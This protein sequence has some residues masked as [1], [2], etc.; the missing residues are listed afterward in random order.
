MAYTLTQDALNFIKET[1][2]ESIKLL[3]TLCQIPAPSGKEELRAEFV[4]KWFEDNG[5]KEVYIDDALN[6]VCPV[7]CEDGKDIIVFMAHTDVVFPDMT[8]LPLVKDGNIY[9]CPGIGDDTACLV[10]MMLVAK[11]VIKKGLTSDY[12]ILFV[13][14]SCEE[15]LGN[16][17]GGREIMKNYGGRVKELYTFDGSYDHI[18][19]RCVGSHRYEITFETEGGHSYSAF[20]KTNAIAEMSKFITDLYKCEVP[21]KEDCK[22]T[23]NVGIVEG[24]TSVNT[25]AQNAKMLYEYRSDDRE[26]LA[27]MQEFFEK[28]VKEYKQN[29]KAE[30]KV[31]LLGDRPC[32]G[33]VDQ[34]RLDKMIKNSIAICE[35]YSGMPCIEES[36]S[37]DCNIPM[38]M[39]VPAVCF[40]THISKGAHTREEWLD[41]T[42]M[43][44]GYKITAE[45]ILSYFN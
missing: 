15:G 1:E 22:T 41:I 28:T 29:G 37:T 4:K 43:P 21:V 12:G 17:K 36:A 20:G 27:I 14:N 44:I 16:L 8:T 33:E 18:Y 39:G 2:Q 24:G 34:A 38:S 7:G 25:I 45:I 9:R 13:A 30:I 23:Y 31:T 42:S 40:G 19:T 26:C 6:V 3:E 10:L 35:K 5:S 32:G 11:Y